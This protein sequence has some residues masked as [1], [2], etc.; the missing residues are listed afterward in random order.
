MNNKISDR[1][2]EELY[3]AI[4]EN[5]LKDDLASVPRKIKKNVL[6]RVMK[7]IND[8]YELNYSEKVEKIIRKKIHQETLAWPEIDEEKEKEYKA[9]FKTIESN[10]LKELC[11]GE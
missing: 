7:K 4:F 9:K 6:A 3:I 10:I 8:M 2:A 11:E 1:S 5:A